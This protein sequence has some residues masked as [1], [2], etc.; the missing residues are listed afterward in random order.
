MKMIAALRGIP[1]RITLGMT[2]LALT[3]LTASEADA[4]TTAGTVATQ[5]GTSVQSMGNLLLSGCFLAGVGCAGSGIL[6]I[7]KAAD[8]DG[9]DSYG[10]GAWRLGVGGALVGIPPLTAAL[11]GTLFGTNTASAQY[12]TMNFGSGSGTGAQ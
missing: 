5:V 1:N 8:S 11:R 7:K 3:A 4:Q 6:K 2:A 12:N 9:R 10:P